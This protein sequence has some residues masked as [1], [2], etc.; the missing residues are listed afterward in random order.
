MWKRKKEG[1]GINNNFAP[2]ENESKALARRLKKEGNIDEA[3]IFVNS[4][5]VDIIV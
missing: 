3:S 4:K 1:E 5:L 2:L